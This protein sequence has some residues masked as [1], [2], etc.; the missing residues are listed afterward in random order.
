MD[1]WRLYPLQCNTLHPR[2]RCPWVTLVPSICTL[3]S[4]YLLWVIYVSRWIHSSLDL[5]ALCNKWLIIVLLADYYSFT[6]WTWIT[7]SSVDSSFYI[8]LLCCPE[9]T[10]AHFVTYAWTI[11]PDLVECCS[12]TL[13]GH[14]SVCWWHQ[15][16]LSYSLFSTT[17]H[18]Q[19]ATVWMEYD[20]LLKLL[21]P[22]HLKLQGNLWKILE[23]LAIMLELRYRA[24]RQQGIM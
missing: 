14:Q 2:P 5:T 18:C 16:L 13:C 24:W 8:V 3:L 20:S 7:W 17:K 23:M 4:I 1:R 21:V 6:W 22:S 19:G 12:Q 10:W 9:F 15:V 11:R